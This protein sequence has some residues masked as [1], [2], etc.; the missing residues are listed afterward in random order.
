MQRPPALRRE[1]M[2]VYFL[3]LKI[4]MKSPPLSRVAIDGRTT[5]RFLL[6]RLCMGSLATNRGA[7]V[8]GHITRVTVK[9]GV[10]AS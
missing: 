7:A 1:E 4:V 5:P 10:R 2:I 3:R 6:I 9:S 8:H